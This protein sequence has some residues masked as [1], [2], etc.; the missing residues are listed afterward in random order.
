[1]MG[2]ETVLPG[3]FGRRGARVGLAVVLLVGVALTMRGTPAFAQD[4]DVAQAMM[5]L[6]DLEQQVRDL[7]GQ[8]Q[9]LQFQLT[10]LQTLVDRS[11]QDNDDRFRQLEGGAAPAPS[12]RAPAAS[13]GTDDGG[14]VLTTQPPRTAGAAPPNLM[15]NS[16]SGDDLGPSSDPLVGKG[17]PG[18][19]PG[20]EEVPL[21]ASA[22]QPVASQPMMQSAPIAAPG[23]P[24]LSAA[25]RS[26][27]QA[28]IAPQTVAPATTAAAGDP[29]AMAQYKAGYD[30]LV[31]GNYPVA[32]QDFRAFIKQYPTDPQAPDATNWLGEALLQQQDF[33]NAAD[34][35]VT[36]YKTYPDSPRAPDMLLKIGIAL[37]GAQQLDAAC[38]TFGLVASKYANT[39][40]AFRT[41]LKQQMAKANCQG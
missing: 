19:A 16:N 23:R 22:G 41:L 14:G 28:S 37:T 15:G 9:G 18:M 17:R 39:T 13:I 5:R 36:G 25:A 6:Q 33:V 10:Q 40:A 11:N 32:E 2:T 26:Q 29:A 7:T 38:K 8:V 35:L 4:R 1:M 24:V 27:Q 20:A 31:K 12:T 30:A 21:G 3:L 34:V